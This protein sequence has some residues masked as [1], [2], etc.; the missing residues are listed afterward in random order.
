M[1]HVTVL[2]PWALL[3]VFVIRGVTLPGA[4][5]GLAYYLVPRGNWYVYL[6][7]PETWIQAYTQVFFSL[8]IGFGIM[9]AYGSFL[10]RETNIVRN[11]FIIGISDSLT[12]IVSGLAVFSCL[13]Y[14]STPEGGGIPISDWMASSLGIAFTAYPKLIGLIPGG[15]VLGPLFFVMLLLLAIDSA[16]SLV[17]AVIKPIEDK[18]GW[19]HKRAMFT[20]CGLGFACG[21]PFMF[22]SGLFW[23]DTLDHFMNQFGLA[24]ACL[25]E[26]LVFG[27][28]YHTTRIRRE[29]LEHREN[30]LG[31]WWGWMIRYVAPAVL[32]GLL[33]WEVMA[34]VEGSYEGY[35]RVTEFYGGWA[36]LIGLAVVAT[37][38]T[39]VRGKKES[40]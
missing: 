19:S 24:M 40:A 14:L 1:V 34:R 11:A 10:K 17:E 38:L 7:R 18:F 13:G 31:A 25:L 5:V 8:S 23:F 16:F 36:A 12:A 20:V 6:Q 27:H 2:L 4:D 32:A 28:V 15:S 22:Q 39:V 30:H 33:M 37:V 3:L 26:C 21:I 9:F 29:L 35:G